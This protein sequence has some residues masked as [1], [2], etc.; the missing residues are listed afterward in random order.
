MGQVFPGRNSGKNGRKKILS[1]NIILAEKIKSYVVQAGFAACG[2]TDA[3]D[4]PEYPAA[5]DRLVKEF[6]ETE[7]LYSSMH[8]RARIKEKFPRAESI[9]VCIRRYGK[10]RIPRELKG[11]IGRNYLFDCRV[12]ENPDYAM[13][14][15]FR[16]FLKSLGMKVHKGGIP[17]RAA[18]VRAGAASI[19]KNTFAYSGACGSWINTVTYV[20][21]AQLEPDNPS[22]P[23]SPCPPDCKKCIDAC[24]TGAIVKPYTM[25]MDRCIAYLTYAAP[26]PLKKELEKKM[27]GWIYGCDICQQVCPLNKSAWEEKESLPHLEKIAG[28][29]TPQAMSVMDMQTYRDI[30]HPLFDY[31]PLED[32]FRWHANAKRALSNP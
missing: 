3:G 7:P 27:G 12:P 22:F 31:I 4:F 30:V 6:P 14:K 20:V 32:I 5:L 18:A 17:D 19:G 28:L 24:P 10:Y 2:I 13:L 23:S 16:E 9:I 1:E 21:D 15:N 29:L 8:R 25:R 11:H 26:L